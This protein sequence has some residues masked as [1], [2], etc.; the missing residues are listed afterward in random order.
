[1]KSD[2]IQDLEPVEIPVSANPLDRAISWLGQKLSL[3]FIFV[4]MISFFE[5]VMRYVFDSPTIWVHETATFIGAALFVIGGL[6]A[7]AN[8]QHVRVVIIYDAVSDKA[9]SWLKLLHHLL[10]LSFCGM[11][12]YASWFMAKSALFAPWGDLR[13]ES[14]G[15]A[16]NPPFPAYLK[17]LI[18]IAFCA[19][20]MQM[21]LHLIRDIRQLGKH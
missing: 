9:R 21:L 13:L 7:F 12:I 20:A 11:M 8:D 15:S 5:V 16:W 3:L 6:Y 17:T 2:L 14:S 1:M 19:L 4:V 10:G 18:F